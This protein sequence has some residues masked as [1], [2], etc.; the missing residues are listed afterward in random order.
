MTRSF[1]VYDIYCARIIFY[2]F[3]SSGAKMLLVIGGGRGIVKV[4]DVVNNTIE[5]LLSGHGIRT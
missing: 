3:R 1:F 2:P 5:C 4:I